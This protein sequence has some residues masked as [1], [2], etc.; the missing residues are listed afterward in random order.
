[1]FSLAKKS[2]ETSRGTYCKVFNNQNDGK[3]HYKIIDVSEF[4]NLDAITSREFFNVAMINLGTYQPELTIYAIEPRP[5]H[6]T[7]SIRR[8][9]IGL[10]LDKIY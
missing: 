3:P 2:A 9:F 5:A 6:S 4:I 10:M 7:I 1:M 8:A